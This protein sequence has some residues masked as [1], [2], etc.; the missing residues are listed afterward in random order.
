M[1]FVPGYEHDVFV[2]YAHVDDDVLPGTE[3]GWVTTLVQCVR[4]RLA[5]ILGRSDSYSL[6]MDH[7]LSGN[8]SVTQQLTAAVRG[9]ATLVV[10]MSPGYTASDWC[11]RE[12]NGFL[13]AIE[14]RAGSGVFVVER[15]PVEESERPSEFKDLAGYPFWVEEWPEKA[16]RILGSPVPEPTDRDYYAKVDDLCRD[17]AKEL[18]RQRGLSA[19]GA[20]VGAQ[21]PTGVQTVA[22]RPAGGAVA[23]G[24]PVVFLAETTDDLEPQRSGIRRFLSQMS[25]DAL[26]IACYAQEPGAFRQSVERDLARC[27]L[28]VQLISEAPG[29]KPP[30]LPGG[31][32]RLQ[33][34]IAQAMNKPVL[35]WRRPGMDLTVVEDK[36]HRQLLELETVRAEGLEEFK[37]EIRR[38]ATEP[39]VQPPAPLNAFVFVDMETA[40]R[41]LAERVCGV[42]DTYGAEYS[43]P[44]QSNDPGD[45]RQ[46][47]EQNLLN[48]DVVIVVYGNT[49]ATW[50]RSQLLAFRKILAVRPTPLKALAVFEGPPEAKASV[51]LKLQNMQILNCRQGAMEDQLKRF[52]DGVRGEAG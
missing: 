1:A 47:L 40:D 38:R 22:A 43:L 48:S 6:W 5:Q 46:D 8:V 21:S 45:N 16:V 18:K 39:R 19:K 37:R 34:E 4:T 9:T 27:D 36:E 31:Y 13:T 17:V 52:L 35:Q 32:V 24:H 7:E 33:L 29:K 12:R 15:E 11:R 10:V 50:V 23:T 49:T 51:D 20:A 26:P 25:I 42:L 44:A 30:D 41:P 2:T 3:R 14:A 28:F